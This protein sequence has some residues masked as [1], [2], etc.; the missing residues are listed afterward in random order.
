MK[1]A[2]ILI[3][4]EE[5]FAEGI[6]SGRKRVE[7]RRRAMS[8]EPGSTVWLY[9]KVPVGSIVGSVMVKAVHHLSPT[10]LWEK[11]GSA[12]GLSRQEFFRYFDGSE[13]GFALELEQPER[14][15][16]SISLEFL[17]GAF[18][19]F[20]PPQFFSHLP[21]GHPLYETVVAT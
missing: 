13:C 14:R 16:S 8:I 18:S 6:L 11:F 17:R 12:S 10:R 1:S 3:S 5:R 4:L 20:H 21:V 2:H 9:V 7:L 19:G 15:A